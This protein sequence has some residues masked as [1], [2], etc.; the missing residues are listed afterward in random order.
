M[1]RFPDPADWRLRR[2]Q[3][4]AF[5]R[6]HH[7]VIT[8]RELHALGFSDGGISRLLADGL[9]VRLTQGVYRGG[10]NELSEFGWMRAQLV[11]S[12]R[13]AAL[14]GQSAAFAVGYLQYPPRRVHLVVP[15]K[16][17]FRSSADRERRAG[18][19]LSADDF[20]TV[21][22]LA[23]AYPLRMV[24]R[25]AA[26][27]S[28]ADADQGDFR[29]LRRVLRGAANDHDWLVPALR[30]RLDEGSFRGAVPLATELKGG[31]LHRTRVIKS[32]VEDRFV[33]L[34]R[35]YGLPIPQTNVV[36]HGH[37]IDAFWE[38]HDA[39][40]EIDVYATHRDEIAFERDRAKVRALR[41]LGLHGFAVTDRAIDFEPSEVAIDVA[42]LLGLS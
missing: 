4:Q 41:R 42:G 33:E 12:R 2:R 40:V 13:P 38:E 16:S 36:R 23:C 8:T 31:D 11:R 34:C 26:E 21:R 30:R 10:G 5:L 28:R 14:D 29:V 32:S 18:T 19:A 17:G 15:G 6:E 1:T 9:I 3:L 20:G 7:G 24:M 25:L 39:F 22:G 27:C 35:R 37:E